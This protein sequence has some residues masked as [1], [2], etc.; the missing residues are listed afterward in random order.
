M[1]IFKISPG[2]AQ[3]PKFCPET[4]AAQGPGYGA[5]GLSVPRGQACHSQAGP[6][7][8]RHTL[9]PGPHSR[10]PGRAPGTSHSPLW[11]GGQWVH[12]TSPLSG[13][14]VQADRPG[15]GQGWQSSARPVKGLP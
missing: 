3:W 1:G 15:H 11:P 5:L 2:Y 13:M 10:S 4:T 14:V 6:S 12:T 9:N 7:L 8:I